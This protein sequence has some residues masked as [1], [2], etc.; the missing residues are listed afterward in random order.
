MERKRKAPGGCY[1]RGDTLWGRVKVNGREIRWSL[2]TGDPTVARAR[3][4]AGKDRLIAD[5]HH[6]DAP[7]MFIEAL[8]GWG[9]WIVRRA[10]PKTVTRYLCSLDQMKSCLDGKRLSEVDS[11][12]VA[13]I[14]RARTAEGITNA[15]VKRDLVALSS[16]I[17]FAIDQG[18]IDNNPVLARMKRL[19]ER[20]DPIV[21]P[22]RED[23]D[24]VCSRAPG[25]IRDMVAAAMATGAREDELL[26]SHRE[27]IDHVRRQMTLVGKRNQIRT[28]DLVPFDGYELLRALPAYVGSPLL[29]WHSAGENYKNFVSQFSAIVDRAAQWATEKGVEFRSF[30]FHDLRHWHAIHWLKSGRSIY[31]TGSGTR[32]SR[33]RKATCAPVIS[34]TR[35]SRPPSRHRPWHK[36]WHRQ[37]AVAQREHEEVCSLIGFPA[38]E[39]V[40][41][42]LV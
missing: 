33:P 5:A 12:L 15:T 11:R 13:E 6:G 39:S 42:R 40:R 10:S 16:V 21:L 23:I 41:A 28:I 19:Q 17:N 29:F 9:D 20:R 37:P 26:K 27:N 25:M 2:H 38:K 30:R 3:R 36:K 22:R 7:R 18:W 4:K 1:W 14:I 35:S 31:S 32:V 8:E 34:P 24:L